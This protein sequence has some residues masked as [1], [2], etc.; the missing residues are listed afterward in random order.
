MV[1]GATELRR[2]DVLRA[3][4]LH[5]AM[6]G[7]RFGAQMRQRLERFLTPP[8]RPPH[9]LTETDQR[10]HDERGAGQADDGQPR[11]VIQQQ[12][13]VSGQRERLPREVARGFRNDLL[14]LAD[15]VVDPRQ[16]PA[17]G[18][19]REESGRLAE[20]VTK[21]RAAQIGDDPLADVGHQVRR[22]V[23][24]DALQQEQADDHPRREH[25]V[26]LLGQ[27]LVDDQL[28]ESGQAGRSDGV[29]EHPAAAARRR[30]RRGGRDRAA[31]TRRADGAAGCYLSPYPCGCVRCHSHAVRTIVSRSA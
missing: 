5:D 17:G 22:H 16:Q 9:A 19:M 12:R 4:R 14:D 31:S 26:L 27:H 7:E 6:T 25:H 30:P 24:T 1:A 18:A 21:Q 10:I 23:R 28:D 15:V 29:D 13:G 2:L 11:V 8:R 3:E 20:D